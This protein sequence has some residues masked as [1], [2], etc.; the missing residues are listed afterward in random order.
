MATRTVRMTIAPLQRV[1]AR[2]ITDPG[3]LAA[4]EKARSQARRKRGKKRTGKE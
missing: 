2:P 4:L 3:K 1:V